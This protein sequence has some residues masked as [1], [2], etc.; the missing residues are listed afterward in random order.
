LQYKA[1]TDSHV[2]SK[3]RKPLESVTAQILEFG[4]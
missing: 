1:I 3:S 4:L 2:K